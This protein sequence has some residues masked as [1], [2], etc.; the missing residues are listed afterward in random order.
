MTE[1]LF[2]TGPNAL[3]A[4]DE[5]GLTE[6][7]MARADQKALDQKPFRFISG[8]PGHEHIL[9]VS[10]YSMSCMSCSSV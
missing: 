6:A 9:D 8:L 4:L 3:H 5:M 7:M 10:L 1:Y 2:D